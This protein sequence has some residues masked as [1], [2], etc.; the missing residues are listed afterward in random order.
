MTVCEIIERPLRVLVC[1][2]RPW[3]SPRKIVRLLIL[4]KHCR[5]FQQFWRVCVDPVNFSDMPFDII[6]SSEILS[7]RPS[8][9]FIVRHSGLSR[10]I[11]GTYGTY[12]LGMIR[13]YYYILTIHEDAIKFHLVNNITPTY[14]RKHGERLPRENIFRE[15]NVVGS[16]QWIYLFEE[17][18]YESV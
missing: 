1:F 17:P 16:C 6:S 2:P 12:V 7:A 3:K 14:L 8:I 9:N 4:N 5:F 15:G 18:M 11:E 13:S 10:I